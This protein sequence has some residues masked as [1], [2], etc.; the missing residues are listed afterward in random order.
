MARVT[1][2]Y[3]VE[4]YRIEVPTLDDSEA[5]REWLFGLEP[6]LRTTGAPIV[7]GF[8][9]CHLLKPSA[10]AFLGGIARVRLEKGARTDFDWSS[11]GP[12]VLKVLVHNGFASAFD[13]PKRRRGGR[14]AIPYR[15]DQQV[16]PDGI[17]RYLREL[18]IGRG[19]IRISPRL[20]EAIAGRMWEIYANA[21]EHGASPVGVI[22]CGHHYSTV[23]ELSLTVVDF[24]I[25]IPENVRSYLKRPT[26][27]A[28][29]AMRWAFRRGTTTKPSTDTVR[30][31]GLDLLKEF[32]RLNDGQLECFSEGGKAHISK[33]SESYTI[34]EPAFR[35][36]FLTIK[37]KCDDRFYQFAS[38]AQP[39]QNPLF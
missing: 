12:K 7:F 19:W 8:A 36:T 20:S 6:R 10:V 38:E 30:G 32:V 39:V 3:T 11:C 33:G 37:L 29:Q 35:G 21:F 15:E 14:H 18:W 22:S 24:G 9:N 23:K 5:A 27:G 31:I 1:Q 4:P 34:V 28:D 25:G 13:G 26:L 17:I 16:D 2:A